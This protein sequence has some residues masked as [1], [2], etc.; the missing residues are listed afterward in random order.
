MGTG[1]EK[2]FS[3]IGLLLA[4]AAIGL[5]LSGAAELWS[6]SNQREKE[7][8]LLFAGRQFREAIE[9]YHARTPGPERSYPHKL[10]D[11]L[12]DKRYPT[13]QRYLRRIYRDPMT[14]KAD[15][16]LVEA[17]GGG[18]MGVYSK[19]PGAPV[20]QKGF[21]PTEPFEGSV[22]YSDW[23]FVSRDSVLAA[24]APCLP[25]GCGSAR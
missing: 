4:V 5:A 11:L 10:E 7:R 25:P 20:K 1:E 15:W 14:R 2:G 22:S 23:K 9:R 18:I 6:H 12:E 13:V 8:E 3:Y 21:L 24:Q 19:A 16:G 17:P